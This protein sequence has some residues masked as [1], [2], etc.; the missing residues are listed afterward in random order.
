MLSV[1]STEFIKLRRSKMLLLAVIAS[2][3]PA[4]VKYLQ[5][6]LGKSHD[7]AGWEWFLASGQEY[8]VLSMLIAIVLVSSFI[9][10]LE[11]QYN[12]VPYIFTSCTSKV[13]IFITKMISLL[14]IIA[15]LFTASA[16][17]ELLFGFLAFKSGLSWILFSEFI[18]VI[19]WYIF[20][21][22]LL[23]TIVVMLAVL[24]KRFV[25]S[26]VVVLGYFMLVFPFHL[27]NNLYVCPF[28]TPTVVAAKLYGAN[29]Y[30]FS[31]YYKDISVNTIGVAAFLV[32]LAA[33]SLTIG[34][35]LYNKQDVI[36]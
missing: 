7:T 36:A 31:N 16:F 25:I 1:L 22:F 5:Y 24:I 10:C 6:T 15:A 21:Y 20:S 32:V 19:V 12:T 2:I 35:I 29:N 4:M 26:A 33:I 34:M 13:N 3:I 14:A 28:M 11:F 8:M 27:K 17:S 9:F 18:K 30:I 23:S